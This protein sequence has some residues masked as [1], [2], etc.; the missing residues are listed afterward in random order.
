MGKFR[1]KSILDQQ[2]LAEPSPFAQ[3]ARPA[4]PLPPP[5]QE[6]IVYVDRIVEVPVEKIVEKI[7]E[8]TVEVPVERIK[9]VVET[10]KVEVPVEKIVEVI[11]E[12]VLEKPVTVEVIKQ[13]V[14]EK[15]VEVIKTKIPV[16]MW[17]VIVAEAVALLIVSLT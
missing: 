16:L 10:V 8:K 1:V 6:K 4:A 7:V 17:A 11:K 3:I 9:R 12:V 14:V 5:P 2:I 13:V 15:P